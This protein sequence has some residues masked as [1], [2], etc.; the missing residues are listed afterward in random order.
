M[1]SFRNRSGTIL[2]PEGERTD[3][4]GMFILVGEEAIIVVV[5]D[6]SFFSMPQLSDSL[7]CSNL[8][9]KTHKALSHPADLCHIKAVGHKRKN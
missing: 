5:R 4:A 9:G 8:L 7:T 3:H 2:Q 6:F 1:E